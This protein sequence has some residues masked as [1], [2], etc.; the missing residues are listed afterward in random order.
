ML[1]DLFVKLWKDA[2]TI[3]KQN[4]LNLA[5]KNPNAKIL[6]LGCDDGVWTMQLA[7]KIGSR[8]I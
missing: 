2:Y 3:N 6:D 1:K 8:Q 4:I 5:D 7:E